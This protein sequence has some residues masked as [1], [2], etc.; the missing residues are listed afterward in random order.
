MDLLLSACSSSL[1]PALHRLHPQTFKS[2]IIDFQQNMQQ[3]QITAVHMCCSWRALQ[4]RSCPTSLPQGQTSICPGLSLAGCELTTHQPLPVNCDR[5]SEAVLWML[6]VFE[7]IFKASPQ[8]IITITPKMIGRSFN[9]GPNP[10][11]QLNTSC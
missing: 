9:T 4:S 3:F 6:Q 1:Q 11:Q 8:R 5:W 10:W 7:K 2:R